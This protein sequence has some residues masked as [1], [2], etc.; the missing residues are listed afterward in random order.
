MPHR[1]AQP[2]RT[3]TPAA[4][5]GGPPAGSFKRARIVGALGVALMAFAVYVPGF[6][7][8][9][10]YDAEVVVQQDGRV[11]TLE[12]PWRLLASSYWPFDQERL[13]LYR[14]VVTLSFAVD[15]VLGRGAPGAFHRTNALAHALASALVF[16]LLTG[17]A[18]VPAAAAGAALF[19]VHPVHTE[20]V[21]GIVGRADIFAA[22]FSFAAL[23][24]W[25]RLPPRGTTARLAVPALFLLALGSKES[26]VMLPALL[27]LYDAATG[28]LVR[29]R[30]RE[31]LRERAAPLALMAGVVLVWTAARF[32]VLGGFAPQSINAVLAH[33]PDGTARVPTALQIW[34]EILRLLIAPRVL[35]ADYGPRILLPV[36]GWSPRALAGLL[37]LCGSIA[38]GLLALWRGRRAAGLALLWA[39]IALFP[40]TNLVIPIGVLMAE[41]TLYIAVFALSLGAA[42]AI[43]RVRAGHRLRRDVLVAAAVA[44]V[45][46]SART[47]TRL[48]A[49]Q[50][51]DAVF[52]ALLRDRPDSY[53]AHWQHARMAWRDGDNPRAA[54]YYRSAMALWPYARPVL[55]EAGMFANE[56]RA[57]HEAR[58]FA[59]HALAY[60]PDDP[61]FLRR[62]AVAALS[63]AD[64]TT[65]RDALYRGLAAEPDDP[66]F[67]AMQEAIGDP[68]SR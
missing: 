68:L 32:A 67:V 3:T 55:L 41:R 22:G 61:V 11:H 31:W 24:A 10:A 64:T 35:L 62:L 14:P 18:P 20:A 44:C 39:P 37:L 16:L 56:T 21:A 2:V 63:L 33:A 54:A 42:L 58:S 36:D 23:L 1:T 28:R 9:F 60:F 49:W 8:G 43:D 27:I 52:Q 65:A 53:R 51:T 47:V 26:A 66:L 19:A 13:A 15:W 40:V 7:N 25:S 5:G 57:V 12:R 30:L 45:L 4:A 48:P 59:E 34:P 46:F 50:S 29:T 6:G 38:G 17:L